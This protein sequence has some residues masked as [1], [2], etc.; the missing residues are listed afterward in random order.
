MDMSEKFNIRLKYEDRFIW[1][2]DQSPEEYNL[3][4]VNGEGDCK[5]DV[6]EIPL[7]EAANAVCLVLHEQISMS[8][9]DL[10]KES[11]KLMNFTRMGSNV[12]ASFEAAV[13][14]VDAKGLLAADDN[15]NYRLSESGNEYALIFD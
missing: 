5:R 11:A 10:I 7:Q 3:I 13:Q 15:G 8:H 6:K 4:R 2:K 14:Y 12:S 9:D 1:T